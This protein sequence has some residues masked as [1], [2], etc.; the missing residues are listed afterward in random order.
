[1]FDGVRSAA[2]A[3]ARKG[4]DEMA[5][6]TIWASVIAAASLLV[7]GAATAGGAASIT[8]KGIQTVVNE[9]QGKYAVQGDLLGRWNTTAFTTN[10]AGADGQFVG[11]GK[12]LFTGCRDTD[13]S[14]AC[15]AG[16]PA[17]TIRFSF[18]YWATYDPKTKALVKGQCVHPVL[19]GTGAFAGAKG[20]IHMKDKPAAGGTRTTYSGTL[21]YRG[22][23]T[24]ST[25]SVATRDLAGRGARGACGS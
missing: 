21:L 7:V 17:G 20:V 13:R 3:A 19:G 12:E 25:A 1:V 15:D 4:D 2:K 11:S 22:A 14:G 5:R 24:A 18:V 16:E 8:V 23:A 9:S 6:I 10:Y